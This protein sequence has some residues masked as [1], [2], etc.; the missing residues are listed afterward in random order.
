MPKNGRTTRNKFL[1]TYNLLKLDHK[2]IEN[3]NSLI[4]NNENESVTQK[5]SL[6]KLKSRTKDDFT[7]EL[8]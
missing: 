1:K 7:G 2:E 4:T 5:L 6:N 3:L 8:Y